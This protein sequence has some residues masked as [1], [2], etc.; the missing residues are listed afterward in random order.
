MIEVG[1]FMKRLK[2]VHFSDL[3]L[4][5]PF[6]SLGSDNAIVARRRKDLLE[7]FDD[8]IDITKR[9]NADLLLI[10]GDLYEHLYVK[11]STIKHI[12]NKFM[13]IERTKVFIVPGNHDP[14]LNNSYYKNFEW[15]DNVFILS[16]E[17]P[18]IEIKELNTCIYG[19]GFEG[20]YKDS[21]IRDEIKTVNNEVL[22]I[23]LVHGTVD[24]N[25][26]K[27]AYNLL[28]S[29]ELS[30][31]NMDYIALGHFHN[32]KDNIGQKGTIYNPGSP[33]PL[34]FD[35][36]GEHC[37]LVGTISKELLNIKHINVSRRHYKSV[38]VNIEDIQSNEEGAEIIQ[39]L[40]GDLAPQNTLLDVTLKGCTKEEVKID[41]TK[42]K[43]LLDES[44][45]Y[46]NVEDRT[47]P[48][49]DYEE[50]KNEPGLKGLYVTKLMEMIGKAKNEKEK[51]LLMKSL[52]Y[53]VEALEKG[54][55]EEL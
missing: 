28:T 30:N 9:E 20:F 4:D 40:L 49:Y 36:E 6:R 43:E 34:G 1:L 15:S 31:L 46:V 5:S 52:Y 18:K 50:L 39:S 32:R 19:L 38:S 12:N 27:K 42:I 14:Y 3:H 25:F 54:K 55:I 22:N 7:V 53:G 16:D 37:I 23:L 21:F 24:M 33:E 35:E 51:Y 8:I 45:F 29:E 44:L 41:G 11:K 17:R 10:S 13:E 48:T 26:T 47:I 2:F